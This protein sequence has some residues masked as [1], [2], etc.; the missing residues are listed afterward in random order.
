MRESFPVRASSA[1][2][3]RSPTHETRAT[4]RASPWGAVCTCMQHTLGRDVSKT[5]LSRH[6]DGKGTT[7]VNPLPE[8]K[9]RIGAVRHPTT[10]A[11]DTL[12]VLRCRNDSQL[13]NSSD[14]APNF[15][16]LF[17]FF[18]ALS[19]FLIPK[20]LTYLLFV[21]ASGDEE[22][23]IIRGPQRNPPEALACP[24]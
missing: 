7:F 6:S 1:H 15:S 17:V 22:K 21:C 4:R 8:K 3:G 2:P 24:S 10:L 14:H 12:C 19:F 5:A 20:R 16:Q 13:F 9:M 23:K 18:F 11:V